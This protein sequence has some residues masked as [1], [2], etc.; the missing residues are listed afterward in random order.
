MTRPQL[1]FLALVAPALGL[2][3]VALALFLL[4]SRAPQ[5]FAMPAAVGNDPNRYC[6]TWQV[7]NGTGQDANDL[8]VRL[9]SMVSV[10]QVY[11]GSYNTFGPA[12]SSS[13]YD[14]A[15]DVYKLNSAMQRSQPP[16]PCWWDFARTMERWHWERATPHRFPGQPMACHWTPRRSL[17]A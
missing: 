3:L 15:A 14:S 7:F 11:T 16:K 5:A 6:Y 12:D 1:R 9:Q 10:S 8:H 2:A 17:S 4:H 13:G